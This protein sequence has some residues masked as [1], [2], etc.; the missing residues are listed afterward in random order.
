MLKLRNCT[1]DYINIFSE[2]SKRNTHTHT[3]RHTY[4]HTEQQEPFSY[5]K[6][7]LLYILF[8][9]D[10][11]SYFFLTIIIFHICKKRPKFKKLD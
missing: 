1:P 2:F 9:K 10:T 3:Q 7:D 11:G 4:M 8:T 6:V 5:P